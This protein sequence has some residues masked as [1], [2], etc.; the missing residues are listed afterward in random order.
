MCRQRDGWGK[1]LKE[2]DSAKGSLITVML[3]CLGRNFE[4]I[5]PLSHGV[6]AQYV[7]LGLHY[8]VK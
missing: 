7:A 2:G 1:E 3:S 8:R 4:L 5:V 6:S